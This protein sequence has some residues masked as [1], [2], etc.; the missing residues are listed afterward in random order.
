MQV[1]NDTDE[2]LICRFF[3]SLKTSIFFGAHYS[4]VFF[5][6]IA[7]LREEG[8][9]QLEEEQRLVREQIQ[10]EKEAQ[11]T[12]EYTQRSMPTSKI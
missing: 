1:T 4:F 2:E 11:Q 12:G 3:L 6:K 5:R 10:R 8:S 9:R 7:R